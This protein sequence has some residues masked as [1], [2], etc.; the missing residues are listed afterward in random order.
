MSL[1]ILPTPD[2]LKQAL[3]LLKTSGESFVPEDCRYAVYVRKSTDESDKQIRSLQDQIT[4]CKEF[5]EKNGIRV[6][7]EDIIIE[8]ESAKEPD[9]RV[10]F[11]QLIND[12]K[13]GKYGGVLAWHPDRLARNMKEAGEVIDLV[14]KNI[15]KDL[16][17]VSFTFQNDTS[18]KMLLGITFVLSKEYSDKLS[19]NVSR[20]NKRS[21]EEGR[22]INK[23]KHGYYKDSNQRLQ[24]DGD[25]F[26][27]IKKA[28][29]L[30]LNG[31]IMSE[32]AEFLKANNYYRWNSDRTKK[33]SA[34][35][36]QK[37]EQF[38]KDP[39]YTGILDYGKNDVVNLIDLYGF[40]PAVS[41]SDF[42]KINKFTKDKQ[43]INIAKKYRATDSVKADLMRGMILCDEC[44]EAMSAGISS[45]KTKTGKTLY[46]YYRCETDDCTKPNKSVRAKTIIDYICWYLEGKPFS[47]KKSYKHYAEEM[48]RISVERISDAQSLVLSLQAKKRKMEEGIIKI[49]EMLISDET[50]EVKALYKGDLEKYKNDIKQTD[51]DIEKAQALLSKGK[52]S[53]LT[54]TDFLEL[55]DNMAKNIANSKDMKF[56]DFIIKKI[57][58]NFTI[59]GKKVVN[60]TLNSPFDVLE[61]LQVSNGGGYRTRTCDLLSVNEL[62]YQ[63]S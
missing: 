19:D 38:M 7:A 5:A 4:E 61:T 60:S 42:M 62:L 17:F 20:G 25:N 57:F 16:K 48:K 28:F 59:Q 50:D 15:I 31:V 14:D 27:L 13:S 56:L 33:F 36:K 46:F 58:L 32:I 51:E 45:K 35:N 30:R 11:R 1:P 10:K 23:P 41:V 22:Y 54:H 9:T 37:V 8:A 63:L 47:S 24:P 55:M 43:L 6:R 29:N 18:G 44:G 49:K 39:V 40:T 26:T 21:I 53:I 34:M 52:A 3:Q 12:L 2:D